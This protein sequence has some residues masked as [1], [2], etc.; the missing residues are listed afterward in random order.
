MLQ[1]LRT[2]GIGGTGGR[3]CELLRSWAPGV[4]AVGV[5]AWRDLGR[6]RIGSCDGFAVA[7]VQRRPG[8]RVVGHC[9]SI[10]VVAIR[11]VVDVRSRGNLIV[12]RG[13]GGWTSV[14][15]NSRQQGE[16]VEKDELWR[17]VGAVKAVEAGGF[18]P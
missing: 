14:L 7:L 10:A 13:G 9:L 11:V 16:R 1:G 6:S 18:N 12:E 17:R 2:R 8:L 15:S 4:S 3:S 5:V